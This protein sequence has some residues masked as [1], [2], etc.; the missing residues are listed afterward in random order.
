M[1]SAR[2][3]WGSS[4]RSWSPI[5]R[6]ARDASTWGL[7]IVGSAVGIGAALSTSLAGY[8]SDHFGSS[9]A[10]FQPC[11]RCR[12][13]PGLG[14][15]AAAGDPARSEATQGCALADAIMIGLAPLTLPLR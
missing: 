6:A 15:A 4:C 9:I 1:G 12:L 11:I 13:R 7:G 10:C 5:L 2:R 8:A 3:F 14:L